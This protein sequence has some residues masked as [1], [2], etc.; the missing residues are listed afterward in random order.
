MVLLAGKGKSNEV[1]AQ[2]LIVSIKK[3][4]TIDHTIP[5]ADD[6]PVLLQRVRC[7][8][9]TGSS[10]C[11]ARDS[12]VEEGIECRIGACCD[13]WE[14]QGSKA[15]R[16]PAAAVRLNRDAVP[17][18]SARARSGVGS[19]QMALASTGEY[20]RGKLPLVTQY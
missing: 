1:Q 19:S 2:P 15:P 3:T 6:L 8:K 4:L 5:K 11:V 17:R 13:L 20:E 12:S 10:H 18:L 16:H 14:L 7:V 9:N